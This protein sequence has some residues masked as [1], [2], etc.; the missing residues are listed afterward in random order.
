MSQSAHRGTS[1]FCSWLG[2][3]LLEHPVKFLCSLTDFLMLNVPLRSLLVMLENTHSGI[4]SKIPNF[5]LNVHLHLPK[6][7]L[8]DTSNRPIWQKPLGRIASRALSM[9][10]SALQWRPSSMFLWSWQSSCSNRR[11]PERLCEMPE[12]TW[13]PVTLRILLGDHQ[14][15]TAE[16][17]P[18]LLHCTSF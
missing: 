17:R 12:W 8:K 11:V 16:Q 10:L 9:P 3:L 7:I 13:M 14:A 4:S 15:R 5:T 18:V 1:G 2:S 6:K